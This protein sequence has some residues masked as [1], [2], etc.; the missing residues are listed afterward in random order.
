MKKLRILNALLFLLLASGC[1]KFL[2]QQPITDLSDELFWKTA[3]DA[4]L[5]LAGVYDGVQ[6]AIGVGNYIDWGEARSDNFTYGGTGENQITVALNGLNSTTSAANWNTLYVAIG[7]ANSA[8]KYLG[9]I[10]NLPEAS[11]NN[12]L[13][14]ALAIRAYLYFYAIRVWGGVPLRLEPYE[15][16]E[17]ETNLARASVDD[18][19]NQAIIPDLERAYSLSSNS[20]TSVWEINTGGILALQADVYSWLKDDAKVLEMTDALMAL[21]RYGLVPGTD[22]KTLFTGP[23]ST[24]IKENIWSL[25]WSFT[26]DLQGNGVNTFAKIGSSSNTSNYVIDSTVF[27]RFEA[28]HE[29]IRRSITY[30]TLLKATTQGVNS[31]WKFYGPGQDGKVALPSNDQNEAK[32]PLYRYADILLLRAEALNNTGDR[33]SAVAILNQVKTR[34]GLAAVSAADFPSQRDLE[35]EIL[36]ERQLELF[37]EGHR[38]FDLIRTGRVLE[39]MDPII[40]KRQALLNLSVSGFTDSR[41]ILFPISRDALTRNPLLVQNEPYS[42]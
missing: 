27:N 41:K 8:I 12:Y 16:L 20:N 25:N 11:L 38:W 26:Q 32:I 4:Q 22:W 28:H 34:A 5:G 40:R 9:K 13:S 18:I 36:Q 37:G 39:V 3:D 7:R 24:T 23:G 42:E 10:A 35:W 6:S 15:N 31:I 33:E 21:K 17:G 1:N 29:D 19:M 2:D 30:D 14:Q